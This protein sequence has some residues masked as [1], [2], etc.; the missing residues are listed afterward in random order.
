MYICGKLWLEDT[1]RNCKRTGSWKYNL[2]IRLYKSG[3]IGRR[4]F[5]FIWSSRGSEINIFAKALS[6]VLEEYN[7]GKEK[8]KGQYSIIGQQNTKEKD[9]IVYLNTS[10]N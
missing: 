5:L 10:K 9:S 4:I 1:N 3:G 6:K 2:L 8:C 7:R